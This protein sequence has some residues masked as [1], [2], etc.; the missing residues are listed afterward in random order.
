MKGAPLTLSRGKCAVNEMT[1]GREGRP[2]AKF[3]T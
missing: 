1:A 2:A 3:A